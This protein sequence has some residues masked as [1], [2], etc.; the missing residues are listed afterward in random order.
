MVRTYAITN[1]GAVIVVGP[2]FSTEYK[3]TFVDSLSLFR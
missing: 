1:F 3:T 2:T